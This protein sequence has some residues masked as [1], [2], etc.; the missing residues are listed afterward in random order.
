VKK[1]IGGY[2]KGGM[3]YYFKQSQFKIAQINKLEFEFSEKQSFPLCLSSSRFSPYV[4]GL[5]IPTLALTLL[6]NATISS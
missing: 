6:N 3:E 4:P 1:V 2:I 5:F